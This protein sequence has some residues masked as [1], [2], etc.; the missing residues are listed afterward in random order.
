[1]AKPSRAKV[2]KL[3]SEAMAAAAARRAEKSASKSAATRG[4]VEHDPYS[5]VDQEWLAMGISAPV[6]R[7]LIDEGYYTISDLR[8]ASLSALKELHGIGPNMIRILVSEMKKQDIE[9]R[10]K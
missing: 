9:F 8:K 4:E 6:R 5:E 10:S 1:M 2:K 3:Q 7:A